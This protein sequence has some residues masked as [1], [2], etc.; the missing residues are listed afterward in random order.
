MRFY[1]QNA[2]KHKLLV[3]NRGEIAVRIFRACNELGIPSVAV[4]SH[5][6]RLQPHRYKADES[7]LVGKGM[8]PVAAYLSIPEV[9]RVCKETGATMIH[10][11][12]G[13]LSESPELAE[14]CE[15]NGITFVGPS[16]D[17]IRSLGHKTAARE[18]AAS[19]N[20]PVVPGSDGPIR[21]A[22]DAR[23]FAEKAGLP[24]IFKAAMGGGGRGM[25]VVRDMS[26]VEEAYS[27]CVSEGEQFFGD[28]TVFAEA[29]LLN[30]RHIEVQ[31]LADS[32]G[33]VVH[34]F[35]RDCSV[36]RRHQKVVEIAPA[37]GLDP[38]LRKQLCDDAVRLSKTAGYR[39]A[40][41][42]EFLVDT[43]RN[44]HYFIEVN[45][46]IQVEHTITEEITGADLVKAQIRIAQGES[47]RDIGLFQSKIR[48]NGSAI[49]CRITTEDPRKNFQPDTGTLSVYRAPGGMGV[50]LDD[51]AHGGIRISPH[52]DS[53]LVK[54]ITHS[55]NFKLASMKMQRAL[56]EFRIRGVTT[57]IHFLLNVF[58]DKDFAT[59]ML[60]TS[61][62]DKRPHLFRPRWV[63]DRANRML[64]YLGDIAVNGPTAS[65]AAPGVR[66]HDQLP[67]TPAFREIPPSKVA[68]GF[69]YQLDGKTANTAT[70]GWR[71]LLQS[72]G[73]EAF[74]QAVRQHQGVL[75]TDTT[76]RDAHQSLLATRVRTIDLLR[77][78]PYHDQA[79]RNA[80]SL[81]VWGGATFDVAMRF[82]HECP[83]ERLEKLRTLVPNVPFQML[84]RGNNALGY[85][86]Y[87][88]NLSTQFCKEAVS[89][90]MDVFRVFDSLNY[91]DSLLPGLESAR[92]SG[93]VVEAAIAYT[94]DV[95]DPT[96]TNYPLEY[97]VKLARTIVQSGTAHV[98]CIKDMA[99][100]LTPQAATLLFGTLR[101][102]HPNMPLH[103]HT[104]D[105]SGLG[106]ATCLAA[107][108]AGADVIDT[109]VDSMS[110][111]T[112]QPSMGAVVSALHN[113]P[114]DTGVHMPN[115]ASLSGFWEELRLMYA[116]FESGQKS[117]SCDVYDNEI[118]GGQYTN[119]QFQARS[120][121]L[122]GQWAAVKEAYAVANKVLGDIV[123]VTPSSK[124][125]GDLAQFMVQNK[126]SGQ[127]VVDQA[128]TL[129]FPSSVV[130][131]LRGEI[132]V[133]SNGFPEPLRTRVLEARGLK[134]VEGL[135]GKEMP[136]IDFDALFKDLQEEHGIYSITHSHQPLSAAMFPDVF[137]GYM[138]TRKKFGN[139]AVLPTH[140]FVNGLTQGVEET[141]EIEKGKQLVVVLMGIGET[142]NDKGMRQVFFHLNGMPRTIEV[143]DRKAQSLMVQRE[144][145]DPA[146]KAQVGA[147]MQGDLV[148]VSVKPGDVVV[149]GQKLVVLSAMKMEMAVGAPMSGV[150]KR[151]VV[152]KGE[153]LAAGDLI[154]E[155]E[156]HPVETAV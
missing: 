118:P 107:A 156:P 63:R 75:V 53:L 72:H 112:S 126:L 101:A 50:R 85:S 144:R 62:I 95:A 61:F 91:L 49:Q 93:A 125:V 154:I 66:S 7:Y 17:L 99:G 98:I 71:P 145:V 111:T 47:L 13:F 6:D 89:R 36:Q 2:S 146:N 122:S 28:G 113:S 134:P 1:A 115:I 20:V 90:G 133:P 121:G 76:M 19:A 38:A 87:P 5:E 8:S 150:V 147:P 26:E 148:E 25:R 74:A 104:H 97:Y 77:A 32:Q 35:E 114:L 78:A 37:V 123:K 10:P 44:Q 33:D 14:A 120:L 131:F 56:K 151:V 59:G 46:R 51:I 58:D 105:T 135:P 64:N 84:L 18:L 149:G 128:S 94:G 22:K 23:S 106:A 137:R 153:N 140:L 45:P 42:F 127:D 60:D 117:G 40:G 15:K 41:T 102:E 31:I 81:E 3:C 96:R 132:G 67:A 124:V 54:C 34:L 4:F 48:A 65:G 39:N 136:P 57:N 155:I 79:L 24:I 29:Y 86:S 130:G 82:L 27:R 30:P 138:E 73:P 21:S 142:V 80:Y 88:D 129:S 92:S 69:S 11:G 16:S 9:M 55:P 119:L 70:D 139:L 43:E 83:W 110:G 12:Y 68:S 116:P 52:Y 141:I 143:P 152:S 103:L 108:A 109:A 100:L